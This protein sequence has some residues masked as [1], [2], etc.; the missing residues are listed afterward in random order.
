MI[1]ALLFLVAPDNT[2]VLLATGRKALVMAKLVISIIRPHR[3]FLSPRVVDI[4]ILCRCVVVF[5]LYEDYTIILS[6]SYVLKMSKDIAHRTTSYII[7]CWPI[8]V[9]AKDIGWQLGDREYAFE[10]LDAGR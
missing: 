7:Y 8:I 5:S 6:I 4:D 10:M 9:R 1:A 2:I 3:N